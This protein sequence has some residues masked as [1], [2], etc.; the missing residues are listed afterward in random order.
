MG[1]TYGERRTDES[2][3]GEMHRWRNR[4][5]N[6]T[7]DWMEGFILIQKCSQEILTMET[8]WTDGWMDGCTERLMDG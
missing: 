3:D 1:N 4:C 7:D 6:D 5:L 8:L 2:T